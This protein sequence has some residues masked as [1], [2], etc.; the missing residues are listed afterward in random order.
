M[1]ILEIKKYLNIFSI[2]KTYFT[3]TRS[4]SFMLPFFLKCEAAS[5]TKV[6]NHGK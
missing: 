6:S 1:L 3:A 5:K 4:E 2:K